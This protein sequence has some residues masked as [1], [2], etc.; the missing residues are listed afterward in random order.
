MALEG[1]GSNNE[2]LVQAVFKARKRSVAR[3]G[4]R[5][6]NDSGTAAVRGA[7]CRSDGSIRAKERDA[8]VSQ[9]C[10]GGFPGRPGCRVVCERPYVRDVH[11]EPMLWK[12]VTRAGTQKAVGWFC[13]AGGCRA[14]S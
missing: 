4:S 6:W 8:A 1:L 9:L 3:E 14:A 13:K 7:G 2:Q 12:H 11:G 5:R 10:D